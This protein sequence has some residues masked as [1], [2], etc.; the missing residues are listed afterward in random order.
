[1]RS[2]FGRIIIVAAMMLV[3]SLLAIGGALW[4][5]RQDAIAETLRDAGNIA[6]VMGEQTNHATQAVDIVLEDLVARIKPGSSEN[7][8]AFLQRMGTHETYQF[9]VD[10]LARLPQ[11]DVISIF[12]RDGVMIASTR[13][14]PHPDV[15]VADRDYFRHAR[16]ESDAGMFI[17]VPVKNRV[18]LES[19]VYFSRRLENGAGSFIGDVIVGVRPEQF[20]RTHDV[21]SSIA[22]ASMV[23]LRGDGTVFL[24]SPDTTERAGQ[25]MPAGSDWYKLV[26][27]GGG[28]YRS[29]GVF[30]AEPRWVAV[31]PL[32]RYPLVVNVAVSEK[33]ALLGWRQR[34]SVIAVGAFIATVV[35]AVLLRLLADKYLRLRQ[36]EEKLLEREANL[37][38][39]SDELLMANIRFHAALSHMTQ[40][41]AMYDEAGRVVICNARYA[42]MYGLTP[43]EVRP[44]TPVRDILQR[45]IARGTFA[46]DSA[47][48]YQRSR[49]IIMRGGVTSA[50][51]VLNDG[52]TIMVSRQPVLGGG[53]VTTHED[54][55]ERQR[56]T[57][58]IA[59][60][61]HHDALTGLANRALFLQVVDD[62]AKGRTEPFAV[63]LID[64]D[65]FKAVNDT[66][67]H[68]AGDG[69]LISVSNRL[70]AS[71]RGSDV[72]ARLGGDEFAL[73]IPNADLDETE[74]I[75]QRILDT[76][77]DA[78]MVE[79]HQLH[80]GASI[81]IAIASPGDS[82]SDVMRAADLALYRAKSDGRNRYRMFE[83][84]MEEQIQ[85]KRM[86]AIDLLGAVEAGDLQV[87]YQPII[88]IQ[89]GAVCSMEALVR[90]T[91]A[92]RG[93]I[94]PAVFIPIAE[95]AGLIDRSGQ[96]VLQR[97]CLEASR[98]PASVKISVNVS[99]I[100]LSTG[101]LVEIVRDTLKGCGLDPRRLE[102][103]IT[104]SVLLRD[105]SHNLG[106]LH[107]LRELGVAIVLDDFGTGY[108]SLSYLSR[109]PLDKVKIDKSFIDRI[110]T[111][112]SSTAIVAAT[113]HIARELGA[114]TTAEGVETP[115]QAEL[116]RTAGVDQ[117]Q[118]YLFGRPLPSSDWTFVQQGGVVHI[119]RKTQ[120]RAA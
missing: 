79:D 51:E 106:I 80:V 108:S 85:T 4:R 54:I 17:S 55:S 65:E 87:Y 26:E 18:T 120:S 25:K 61:A 28:F 52:R 12:D 33:V 2:S 41:L 102:L 81:G 97:A 10:R 32:V 43:D 35:L 29:G 84:E 31:R 70:S 100:Q 8:E 62:L 76:V 89:S 1:M 15:N 73:V 59:H 94:S 119:E 9:L 86:L 83:P 37:A 21:I 6:T 58:Q 46:G 72:I 115:E 44:G 13:G 101:N 114:V 11:A 63:L 111:S 67:G 107:E 57:A 27:R 3:L 82:P 50:T 75:A 16:D 14:W 34:A 60:M 113:T 53:W 96:F 22:G 42:T 99:P 117:L 112:S 23:L 110:G 98:W 45:R 40:G 24:R 90:W 64:L 93:P 5:L 49:E 88:D 30:D 66:F 69:L 68:T 74:M 20:L 71:I 48:E 47:E 77:K 56:A 36:S 118:G 78:H 92:E 7:A 116:L 19:T 109:F 103:E 105:D 95:E 104:E 38:S 39:K 91:H